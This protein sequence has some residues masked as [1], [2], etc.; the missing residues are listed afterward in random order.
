MDA[1][2]SLN[3]Y[4]LG[5]MNDAVSWLFGSLAALLFVYLPFC[6]YLCHHNLAF[7]LGF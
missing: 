6:E 2:A 7:T 1:T 5:V 4:V 3:I